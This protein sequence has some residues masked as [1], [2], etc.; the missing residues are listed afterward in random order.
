MAA[1]A[2]L[3]AKNQRLMLAGLALVAVIGAGLIAVPALEKEAT[4]FYAPSDLARNP[5]APGERIRLGGLVKDGSVARQDEGLTL[6]FVVTDGA[7]ETRVRYTGIV[8][9]LFREGQGVVA[10]GRIGPDG[11]FAA[12][13]L[14]AKHDENYMPPEVAKSLGK[15]GMMHQTGTLAGTLPE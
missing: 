3:N 2:S 13:Q 15:A 10:T 12:D 1:G 14:L 11:A 5:P 7:H 4:F 9:D 6:A 8:P